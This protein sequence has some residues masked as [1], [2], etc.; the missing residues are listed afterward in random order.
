MSALFRTVVALLLVGLVGACGQ[1]TTGQDSGSGSQRDPAA[2]EAALIEAM[3]N[4]ESIASR[5]SNLTLDELFP[6]TGQ[7]EVLDNAFRA[8][9][10][11]VDAGRAFGDHMDGTPETG[12]EELPFD[13]PKASWR[14]FEV[15][16]KVTELYSGDVKPGSELTIGLAFGRGLD[17]EVVS[18]GLLS[19]GEIVVFT[20]LGG[21]VVPYDPS[22]TPVVWD[23]AFL[24]P[25]E[26][27]RVPWPAVTEDG[28][29]EAEVASNFDTLIELRR[30]AS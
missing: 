17:L 13:D 6:R 7:S 4:R 29:F 10:I 27:G 8:D 21:F 19:M 22:I 2:S 9:V 11:S 3:I 15:Q 16:V 25:V 30:I 18:E 12:I 14:S 24:S 1:T 20:A 23:G 5:A 28:G 26:G